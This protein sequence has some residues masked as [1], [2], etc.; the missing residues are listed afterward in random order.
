MPASDVTHDLL[1]SHST[2]AMAALG[3]AARTAFFLGN[4]GDALHLLQTATS[5][6]DAGEVPPS[7]QLILLLKYGR[8][9]IVDQLLHQGGAEHLF[10]ILRQAHQIATTTANQQGLAEALNL[11][12]QAHCNATT[13]AIM[14]RGDLP[15]GT[16]GPGGYE[17]AL[18]YQQ[19]ALPLQQALH[20]TRGMSESHFFL[21]LVY[22]FW[23]QHTVARDHVME[24]LQIAEQ[25][26][27][28]L[29]QAEPH[30]HLALDARF[31]GDLDQALVHAQQALACRE[32]AGFKP[33]QPFDHVTLA[34][35]YG[36]TGETAKAQFHLQQATALAEAMGLSSLVTSL[37][38]ATNRLDSSTE[39]V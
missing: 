3:E 6:F 33:Y 9:L 35:L 18:S 23:Q 27:H 31:R 21:G 37:I 7:A 1:R 28:V 22:Q 26:G 30:R 25:S 8:V 12:G 5:L 13:V 16:R 19:Q 32:A 11:L 24:A 38:T 4:V 17:E 20:D 36:K 29:E 15:F 34:D 14:K 39:E 2:T 10:A